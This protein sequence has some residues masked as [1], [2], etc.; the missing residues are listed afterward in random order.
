MYYQNKE[1]VGKILDK[2]DEFCYTWCITGGA[3]TDTGGGFLVLTSDF[4]KDLYELSALE[5]EGWQRTLAALSGVPPSEREVMVTAL[6]RLLHRQVYMK[7]KKESDAR[8]QRERRVL[9][10][11]SVP[12]AFAERIRSAAA[13]RGQSLY[14]WCRDAFESHLLDCGVV[15]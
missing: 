4:Y 1:K 5:R 14:R 9:I 7:R 12:L 3:C 15:E 2:T 11:A 6:S 10:G 13:R 8:T